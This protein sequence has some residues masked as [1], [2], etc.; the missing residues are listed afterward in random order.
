MYMSSWT[1]ENKKILQNKI[2]I[3]S[4]SFVFRRIL[5]TTVPFQTVVL[6]TLIPVQLLAVILQI[7]GLVECKQCL[8]HFKL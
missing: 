6:V 3:Q 7:I 4:I 2:I 8:Y 5:S 1:M